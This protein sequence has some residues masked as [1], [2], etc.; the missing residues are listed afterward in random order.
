MKRSICVLLFLVS[1]VGVEAAAQPLPGLQSFDPANVP[2]GWTA[3]DDGLSGT[4]HTVG[5]FFVLEEPVVL[6]HLGMF[7]LGADGIPSAFHVGL[8]QGSEVTG[9]PTELLSSVTI[10]AGVEGELLGDWRIAPVEPIVLDPGAYTIGA[11][12]LPPPEASQTPLPSPPV[13]DEWAGLIEGIYGEVSYQPVDEET[14]LSDPGAY[15]DPI[16]ITLGPLVIEIPPLV[17]QIPFQ[18]REQFFWNTEEVVFNGLD[19]SVLGFDPRL[20]AGLS[21]PAISLD[22]GFTCPD[23]YY[24][25]SGSFIGPNLFFAPIP[26]PTAALLGAF[27]VLAT[28]LLRR[29]P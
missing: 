26:E 16:V 11:A 25:V 27:A 5:W 20:D 21:S 15:L 8:W 17:E 28:G 1:V 9:T 19:Y 6:S 29:R 3:S 4:G 22:G 23:S 13:P 12:Q 18:P 14:Y 10:P 24:L 2:A 7:D